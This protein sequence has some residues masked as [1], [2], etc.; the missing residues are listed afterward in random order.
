MEALTGQVFLATLVA[1]LVAAYRT[2][3]PKPPAGPSGGG[4]LP[5]D[6]GWLPQDVDGAGDDED[7]D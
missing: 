6:R 2:P 4:R 1:R 3:D 5:A 7:R